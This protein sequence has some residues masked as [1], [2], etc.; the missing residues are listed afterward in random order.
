M[1]PVCLPHREWRLWPWHSHRAVWEGKAGWPQVLIWRHFVKAHSR[2]SLAVLFYYMEQQVWEEDLL[3]KTGCRTSMVNEVAGSGY[4]SP[5]LSLQPE[6]FILTH[7]EGLL[8]KRA[9][10]KPVKKG[11]CANKTRPKLC[12]QTSSM[13]KNIS[14][15]LYIPLLLA[16]FLFLGV[17]KESLASRGLGC[18]WDV[19]VVKGWS[20]LVFLFFHKVL[21]LLDSA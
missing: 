16:P 21:W 6:N 10:S 1:E 11:P 9:L 12:N 19:S 3:D 17:R 4:P 15:S 5:K 20:S 14:G 7:E 2:S 18:G 8:S 13:F